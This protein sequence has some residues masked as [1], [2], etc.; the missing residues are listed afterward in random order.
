MDCTDKITVGASIHSETD[1]NRK[2]E[3][4]YGTALGW[5]IYKRNRPIGL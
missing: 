3:D 4:N 1:K 2:K 5:K